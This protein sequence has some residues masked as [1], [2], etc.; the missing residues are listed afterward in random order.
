L[1]RS[2]EARTDKRPQLSDLRESGAIEQDADIVCLIHRPD[3]GDP[4]SPKKG[5]ATLIVAK[6]RAG[7]PGDVDL[8]WIA[9]QT[10]FAELDFQRPQA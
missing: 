5:I 1:N 4:N 2:S 3:M 9:S 10:K 7:E 8:A 6:N